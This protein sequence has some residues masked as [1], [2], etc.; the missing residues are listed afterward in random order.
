MT[1]SSM[2]ISRMTISSGSATDTSGNFRLIPDAKN[3]GS[4]LTDGLNDPSAET[5]A[6]HRADGRP[7]LM[8]NR[9]GYKCFQFPGGLV[10]YDIHESDLAEGTESVT[11]GVFACLTGQ[12]RHTDVHSDFLL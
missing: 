5:L 4:R 2:A 9:H 3:I 8:L 11:Q 12:I 1:I 6:I 7:C 10:P